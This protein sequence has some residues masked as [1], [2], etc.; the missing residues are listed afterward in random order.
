MNNP[1][2]EFI[3]KLAECDLS[4]EELADMATKINTDGKYFYQALS[5]LMK[6]DPEIDN[7]PLYT[8]A[9]KTLFD[10]IGEIEAQALEDNLDD[11]KIIYAR[12]KCLFLIIQAV[13][14]AEAI[15]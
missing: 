13:K 4:K 1:S 7:M 8:F 15:K 12:V 6:K 11:V 5:K 2:L 10:F 14:E 9:T 3:L